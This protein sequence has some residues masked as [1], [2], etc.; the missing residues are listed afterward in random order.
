[1]TAEERKERQR[2][3]SK[4]K[5]ILLK[6]LR[7][8]PRCGKNKLFGDE[9]HCPECAVKMAEWHAKRY[10]GMPEEERKAYI[11]RNTDSARK[12]KEKRRKEGICIRCGKRKVSGKYAT[13]PLC[14]QKNREYRERCKEKE[15]RE[16]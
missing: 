15:R 4:Q 16:K 13:C 11:Q 3:Y 12:M 1:M 10:R 9:F 14:R 7:I 5:R 2:E 6:K 8:C